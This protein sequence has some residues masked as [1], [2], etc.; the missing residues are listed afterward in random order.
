[1]YISSSISLLRKAV[2]ISLC[3]INYLLAVTYTIS[4]RAPIKDITDVYI[5][6]KSISS[7]WKKSLA[8]YL[9]LN[10]I[11]NLNSGPFNSFDLIIFILK[12]YLLLI[13]FLSFDRLTKIYILFSIIELYSRCIIFSHSLISGNCNIS[14]NVQGNR[15]LKL[16]NS[17][18]ISDSSILIS[19]NRFGQ[20]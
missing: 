17:L 9:F 19:A 12:I 20:W 8:T 15:Y 6:S 14:W 1:M 10:I 16:I 2:L 4:A 13:I 7:R 3:L 5:W 18:L 11:W